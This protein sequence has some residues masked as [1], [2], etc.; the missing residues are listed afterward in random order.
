M[1]TPRGPLTFVFDS[2][3]L[4]AS[5]Q[6]SVGGRSVAEI[7]LAGAEVW[8]PPA[9]YAE[10]ITRGLPRPDAQTAARLVSAGIIRVADAAS[11]GEPLEDLRHYQLGKG[12]EEALTLSVGL[13]DRAILVTDDF[14]ALIVANRLGVTCQLFLDFVVG[15]A[16]RGELMI[17]DAQ[18]IV[19]AISRRY[20]SGFIPH[21]LAM[22]RRLP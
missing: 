4:V 10:V 20:P 17:A 9:V 15:R 14:L 8:V 2:S 7:A 13:G 19:Q 12:E 1:I 22:L 16:T 18:Q 6:S 21:S 11:V 3:P 5:C